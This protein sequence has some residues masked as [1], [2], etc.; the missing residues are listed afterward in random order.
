MSSVARLLFL[1]PFL[2]TVSAW[3]EEPKAADLARAIH[4]TAADPGEV[5][6]VRE[7][8][9]ARED[10]RIYLTEGYLVFSK[11]VEGRRV[12]AAFSSDVEGGDAEVLLLPP[13]RKIGR[14]HV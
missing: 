12:W 4:E 5:Y 7:L 14:S 2:L 6:R 3:C 11:P 8:N 13:T 1:L 10:I 9:F